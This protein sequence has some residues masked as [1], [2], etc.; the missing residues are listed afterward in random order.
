[1][2]VRWVTCHCPAYRPWQRQNEK[3]PLSRLAA[4]PSRTW[5][6]ACCEPSPAAAA[7]S[8]WWPSCV[9]CKGVTTMLI[10]QDTNSL[11]GQ[12]VTMTSI[13]QNAVT[14]FNWQ[15]C[16][17]LTTTLIGWD[18]IHTLS[19]QNVTTT[20]TGQNVITTFIWQDITTMVIGQSHSLIS[21]KQ[22]QICSL[23]K[24]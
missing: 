2:S 17:I 4:L 19:G 12:D 6:A 11:L 15:R 18:E 20:L 5:G 3:P 22:C 7:A 16:N 1:M 10:G 21:F 13:G 8:R 24:M 9:P 23:D 14:T